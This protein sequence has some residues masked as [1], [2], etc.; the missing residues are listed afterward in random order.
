KQRRKRYS[1]LLCRAASCCRGKDVPDTGIGGAFCGRSKMSGHAAVRRAVRSVL[2]ERTHRY[3][4]AGF[5]ALVAATSAA[6][7]PEGAGI[8]EVLVTGSR[9]ARNTFTTPAP[10]TTIDA[11]QI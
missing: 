9:I 5:A 1:T 10:V 8:E 7:E 2:S 11:E 3:T 6:Q 4:L